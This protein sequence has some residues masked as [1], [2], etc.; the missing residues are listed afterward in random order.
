MKPWTSSRPMASLQTSNAVGGVINAPEKQRGGVYG[1]ALQMASCLTNRQVARW[2]TPAGRKRPAA[3]VRSGSI[4][5]VQG[6]AV[7]PLQGRQRHR[8]AVGDSADRGHSRGRRRAG[9]T[10]TRGTA[11]HTDDRGSGRSSKRL[12]VARA[13]EPLQPLRFPGHRPD[14][15]P[16]VLVPRSGSLGPRGDAQT[17][18]RIQ[19]QGLRR[20]RGRSRIP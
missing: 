3:P 6:H 15:H 11:G 4:R 8:R 19:H 10:F 5:S 20:R 13:A 18:E 9:R 7:Q 1:T 12:P 14:D 2:V 17:L 16:S